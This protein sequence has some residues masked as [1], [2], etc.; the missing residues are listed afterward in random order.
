MDKLRIGQLN[1]RRSRTVMDEVRKAIE[2]HKLDIVC[3]QEPHTSRGRATGLPVTSR[4]V[5]QGN[6]PMA[7][8]VIINPEITATKISPHCDEHITTTEIR[9]RKLKFWLINQYFQFNQPT[10]LHIEKLENSI[11]ANNSPD[12]LF[13]GDV[14]A[15]SEQWYNE[16]SDAAGDLLEHL[17]GMRNHGLS[18]VKI[19][20]KK[21]PSRWGS[22]ARVPCVVRS[23]WRKK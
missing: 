8:S 3:L 19:T 5:A 16:A 12:T 13:M 7:I 9:Y 20:H 17:F 21:K 6:E 11:R 14:N 18:E 4:Q 23:G 15:K 1:C 22:L 2:D 10:D